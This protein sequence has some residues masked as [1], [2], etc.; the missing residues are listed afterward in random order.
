MLIG[1]NLLEHSSLQKW[2]LRF[3]TK[4]LELYYRLYALPRLRQQARIALVVGA[5]MYGLYGFLDVL[6]LP[7][8]AVL[9]VWYIRTG[10]ILL[11]VA[12]FCF[13]FFQKFGRYSQTCLALTGIIGGTGLMAKMSFLPDWALTYFYGGLIL[14]TFWVY[15]FSGLRFPN[16]LISGL[17]LLVAFNVA[18]LWMHTLPLIPMVS[19]NFFIISANIVGAFACYMAESQNR[20]LFLR[21]MELD[22]ERRLQLNR[23]LHDNLTSLPN[24]ELLMDRVEQAINYAVRNDQVCAGL[25]LD[26]DGFKP[27]N[28]TYGH[29]TGDLVLQ[30]VAKRFQGVLRDSDTLSRLSGDEFFVLARDIGSRQAAEIMAKKLLQQLEQPFRFKHQPTIE[31]VSASIGICIFPYRDLSAVDVVRRADQAMYEVKR[32]TKGGYAFAAT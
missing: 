24:R 17:I 2:T 19:Y 15:C 10:V 8:D 1:Q 7:A 23:A 31:H 9:K 26:L 14:I 21:E 12:A 20:A 29:A 28:D 3:K 13:T 16:A 18:F 6:F 25:Y 30:E 32:G 22:K 5:V 4:R 11:A 27:I